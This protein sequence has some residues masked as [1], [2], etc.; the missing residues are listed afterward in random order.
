MSANSRHPEQSEGSGKHAGQPRPD[1]ILRSAQDENG[2]TP[3]GVTKALTV[4]GLAALC[5]ACGSVPTE[6]FYTL[7]PA[8][9]PGAATT[10][11][12]TLAIVVDQATIPELVDRP[13]LVVSSGEA[14]VTL[15]EQQRWAEPLRSQIS[16]TV[17]LDL[18][19]LLAPARVATNPDI[20]DGIES[21]AGARGYRV[22]LDVQ[23]FES[24]PGEN[25]AIEVLWTVRRVAGDVAASGRETVQESAAKG[26]YE[27]LI[28]AHNRALAAV[29]RAIAAAIRSLG[30]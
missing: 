7:A 15:L 22:A 17:A 9:E 30:N 2:C 8:V 26:S 28:A 14:R 12:A 10:G 19:Q 24:R 23:R 5:I 20:L 4:I 16:R 25:V 18:T 21:A 29:S 11:I 1:L 6:T 13:Q 3:R 27:S